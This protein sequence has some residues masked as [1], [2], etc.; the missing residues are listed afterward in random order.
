MKH[1]LFT[2][3]KKQTHLDLSSVTVRSCGWLSG[4]VVFGFVNDKSWQI[5]F[6]VSYHQF[7][8]GHVS[9]A[10]LFV[11]WCDLSPSLCV[12]SGQNFVCFPMFHK[13][14]ANLNDWIWN[15]CIRLFSL[16]AF[17]SKGP[18]FHGGRTTSAIS[19]LT[20]WHFPDLEI[21]FPRLCGAQCTGGRSGA[22]TSFKWGSALRVV[23]ILVET[24]L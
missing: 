8:E 20:V 5:I 17:L 19:A 12:C 11:W 1:L 15:C 4:F 10:R 9:M 13:Y 6:T 22:Y 21:H 3:I 16:L 18:Y 24:G 7:W 14:I 23:G 2:Y